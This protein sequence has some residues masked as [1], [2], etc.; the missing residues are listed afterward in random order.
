MSLLVTF[1]KIQRKNMI[2]NEA[3]NVKFCTSYCSFEKEKANLIE[4]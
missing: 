4:A 1:M 2:Y 3:Y